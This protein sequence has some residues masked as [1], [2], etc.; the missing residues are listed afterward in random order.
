MLRVMRPLRVG[1][2]ADGH[3]VR[4]WG[5]QRDVTT[6]RQA[7]A[8]L[9]LSEARFR[10]IFECG[11]IGIGFWNSQHVTGANDVLLG[12]LGYSIRKEL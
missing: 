10:S 1:I 9:Q 4:A 2:V 12:I 8:A 5:S 3:L 11:M 6:K 7:E